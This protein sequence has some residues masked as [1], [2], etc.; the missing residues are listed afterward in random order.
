MGANKDM[1]TAITNWKQAQIHEVMLQ[2][3]I[4]WTFTPTAALYSG[5]IWERQ[6]QT[7]RKVMLSIM[8][9][10]MLN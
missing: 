8:K 3:G 4:K 10:Q 5:G 7:I 9:E 2:K 1:K 6:I